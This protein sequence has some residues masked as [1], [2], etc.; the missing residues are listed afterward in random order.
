MRAAIICVVLLAVVALSSAFKPEKAHHLAKKSLKATRALTYQCQS[1]AERCANSLNSSLNS[2]SANDPQLERKVCRA[3][4]TFYDC[5]KQGTSSCY[6]AQ[7][8]AAMNNLLS[9]GR[10]SCPNEFAGASG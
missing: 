4:R 3:V 5:V 6:D 9:E 7:L 8:N 2:I 1:A 10:A